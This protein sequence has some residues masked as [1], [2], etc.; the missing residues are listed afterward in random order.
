MNLLLSNNAIR[1]GLS[2]LLLISCGTFIATILSV[3]EI[4]LCLRWTISVLVA[5]GTICFT[6][7]FNKE[8]VKLDKQPPTD[9]VSE[10]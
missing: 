4:A 5:V 6:I 7:F 1:Y 3:P 10:Q 8:M 9:Q 2:V